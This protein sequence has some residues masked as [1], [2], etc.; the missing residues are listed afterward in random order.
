MRGKLILIS[1]DK[2]N[3]PKI[4]NTRPITTLPVITKLFESSILHNLKNKTK[5]EFFDRTKEDS[6]ME[7]VLWTTKKTCLNYQKTWNQI[8]Q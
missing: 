3:C 2:T 5:S 6:Q 7:R 1:K 4:E 8:K